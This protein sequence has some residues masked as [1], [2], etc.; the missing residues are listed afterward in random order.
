MPSASWNSLLRLSILFALLIC[1]LNQECPPP[2]ASPDGGASCSPGPNLCQEY[3]GDGYYQYILCSLETCYLWELFSQ[4]G[5]EYQPVYNNLSC[6]SSPAYCNYTLAL[7]GYTNDWV[8]APCGIESL[9]DYTPDSY[10]LSILICIAIAAVILL[11]ASWLSPECMKEYFGNPSGILGGFIL[12]RVQDDNRRDKITKV[13]KIIFTINMLAS[14]LQLLY[15]IIY[16]H[17]LLRDQVSCG[18][19]GIT[20][21]GSCYNSNDIGPQYHA[22]LYS[23]H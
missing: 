3:I 20:Q 9:N 10:G 15:T 7:S 2:C 5:C 18:E 6:I 13:L 14:F 23:S 21:G 16:L 19:V 17:S 4:Y 22:K 12:G 11:L 8:M 1:V